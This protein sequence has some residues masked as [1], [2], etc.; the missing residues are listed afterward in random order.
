MNRRL[1]ISHLR[2]V[3]GGGH[4]LVVA[5]AARASGHRVIGFYDDADDCSMTACCGRLGTFDDYTRRVGNKTP[6]ILAVGVLQLRRFLL[7]GHT[8]RYTSILHP[9]AIVAR[10]S[11]VGPGVFIAAGAIISV[12]ADIGPHNIINTRAVVEHDCRLA[13]NVHVG[14]G[15][16]LG[17]GVTVGSDTLIG[18]NATVKSNVTIGSNC[19][20]GAGAVVVRDVVDGQVVAGVPARPMPASEHRAIA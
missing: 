3:G 10:H 20:V 4:A 18:L 8:G 5:E 7:D 12:N 15:A 17:G 2:L 9:T 13:T 6:A 14:P 19:I 16:V 1:Q 11:Q